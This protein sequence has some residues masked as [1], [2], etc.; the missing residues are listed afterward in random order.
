MQR[1]CKLLSGFH[2]L[3][4]EIY[5][6]NIG[7]IWMPVCILHILLL[8]EGDGHQNVKDS[9]VLWLGEK[10]F[11]LSTGFNKVSS[12]QAVKCNFCCFISQ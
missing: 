3:L 12:K 4:N 9:R 6:Q 8:Q 2:K 11:V 5:C 7:C 1:G 10:D